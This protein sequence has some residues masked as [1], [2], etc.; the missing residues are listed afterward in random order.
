MVPENHKSLWD[1][2]NLYLQKL[3]SEEFTATTKFKFSPKQEGD[4]TGLVIMGEDYAYL[5]CEL[6][7]GKTFI[8]YNTC[9][10]ARTKGVD[11]QQEKVEINTTELYFRVEVIKGG[12]CQFSYSTDGKEY[13]T[14]G[15]LFTARAGRWIGA[16]VGLLALKTNSTNDS[17]YAD[18]DWFR[19]E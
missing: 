4:Q 19:F 12:L 17:G 10:N 7:S 15:Q 16:K 8:T 3:P 5:A 9:K 14:I 11:V 1:V 2:P 6:I 13:K 18:F